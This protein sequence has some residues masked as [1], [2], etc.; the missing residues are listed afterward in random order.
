MREVLASDRVSETLAGDLG[1]SPHHAEPRRNP[2]GSFEII[3]QDTRNGTYGNGRWIAST[4]RA[5]RDIIRIGQALFR[6]AAA[7]RG[8]RRTGAP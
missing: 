7:N 1:V 3:D 4:T 5:E 2:V 6:P 8:G